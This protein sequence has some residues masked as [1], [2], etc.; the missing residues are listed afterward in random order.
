VYRGISSER[1]IELSPQLKE[2][3]LEVT[4]AGQKHYLLPIPAL[5]DYKLLTK[6]VCAVLEL[7]ANL[8]LSRNNSS[9]NVITGELG[10]SF[11]IVFECMK[12][13]RVPAKLRLQFIKLCR[14]L[15]IDRHPSIPL[16]EVHDFC[17]L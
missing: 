16:E 15:Y 14:V 11:D 17:F 4:D 3:A 13:T 12:D 1:L 9:L 6:Y 8:C 2:I 7:L 5:A 10:A